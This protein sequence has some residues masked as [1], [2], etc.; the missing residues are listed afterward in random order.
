LRAHTL[1]FIFSFFTFFKQKRQFAAIF[2]NK[3]INQKINR[4]YAIQYIHV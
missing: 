2:V 3:S 4:M 1:D